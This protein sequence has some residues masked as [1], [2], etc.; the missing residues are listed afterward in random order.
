MSGSNI[1]E[2]VHILMN[3]ELDCIVLKSRTQNI[4]VK[5]CFARVLNNIID[6]QQKILDLE[7]F[8]QNKQLNNNIATSIN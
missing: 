6:L 7:K 2:L 8:A 3:A 4:K 5:E 1:D